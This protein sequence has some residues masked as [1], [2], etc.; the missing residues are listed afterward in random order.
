MGGI[1]EPWQWPKALQAP[2]QAGGPDYVADGEGQAD[3]EGDATPA[4]E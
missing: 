1:W 3:P 2:G 4:E